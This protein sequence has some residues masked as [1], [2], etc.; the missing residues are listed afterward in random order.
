MGKLAASFDLHSSACSATCEKCRRRD[1]SVEGLLRRKLLCYSLNLF[2]P[3]QVSVLGFLTIDA[4]ADHLILRAGFLLTDEFPFFEWK[5]SH[6]FHF[7][8]LDT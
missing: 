6:A 2:P 1:F 7:Y 4:G 8:L 3:Y 5:I